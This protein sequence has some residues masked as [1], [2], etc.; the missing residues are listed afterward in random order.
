MYGKTSLFQF[1][2][3]VRFDQ[4]SASDSSS[5]AP[6]AASKKLVAKHGSATPSPKSSPGV[7][8][9]TPRRKGKKMSK[10]K[11][12][13]ANKPKLLQKFK[14]AAQKVNKVEQA[15]LIGKEIAKKASEAGISEVVF[16]RNGYLYHGRIKALADSARESGLKF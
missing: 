4:V 7:S 15:K 1:Q 5:L 6:P 14:M 12:K 3:S 8:P 2:P 9:Q 16:D 13:M 10:L 11:G